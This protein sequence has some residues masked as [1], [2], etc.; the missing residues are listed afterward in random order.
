MKRKEL[1][2]LSDVTDVVCSHI[3]KFG[4]RN[5]YDKNCMVR[6]CTQRVLENV[7]I[8][9]KEN[10]CESGMCVVIPVGEWR[11]CVNSGLCSKGCEFK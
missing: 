1:K 6:S 7:E 4:K 5:C 2:R 11:R 3:L 10:Q 8:I 9:F